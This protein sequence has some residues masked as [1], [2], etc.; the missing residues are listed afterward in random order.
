MAWQRI[1]RATIGAN[2]QELVLGPIEPPPLD[3]FEVRVRLLQGPYPFEIGEGLLSYR[4]SLG[5]ELGSIRV[6]PRFE[7]EDH[8]LGKGQLCTDASGVLIFEPNPIS[9]QLARDGFLLEVEVWADLAS[10]QI[11]DNRF[12]AAGFVSDK[13]DPALSEVNGLGHLVFPQ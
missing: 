7:A 6:C 9:Q 13:G 10:D 8:L 3:G 5:K 2:S 11:P 12:Q 1:G 4:S